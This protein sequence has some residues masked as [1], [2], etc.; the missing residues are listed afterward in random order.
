MTGTGVVDLLGTNG[1]PCRPTLSSHPEGPRGPITHITLQGRCRNGTVDLVDLVHDKVPPQWT[2]HA[3][4]R[5]GPADPDFRPT[6]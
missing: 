4:G 1:W 3:L 6:C 5:P 2:P